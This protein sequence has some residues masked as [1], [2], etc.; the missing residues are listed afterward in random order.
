VD[1]IDAHQ[2]FWDPARAAYPWMTA[3]LDA[4][5]RPFGPADLEPLL[6][7]AGIDRTILVQTIASIDETREFL[8]LA[9]TSARIAGVVGW[10]DLTGPDGA[11]SIDALRRAPGGFRLAGIRHQVHDESD[12]QWL[13]RADVA[14]GLAAV[15]AAG[16][17]Y[18]LLVRTR[19]LPAAVAVAQRFP[20]LRLVL[21]HCAKPPIATRALPAEWVAGITALAATPNVWCKVSGL[22]TEAAWETWTVDDLRPSVA[23]V[24]RCFGPQRL[25]FGSDWP[26][27]LLAASYER[28]TSAA[29]ALLGELIPDH[30][31][32]AAVF[33]A[34]ALAAYALG[35][36]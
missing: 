32:R 24:V 26:V 14:R 25:L 31:Q 9:A 20:G 34:N 7:A 10:I 15:E 33:G 5:R 29:R 35:A 23:H 21:D 27:C 2:H 1:T 12:P 18:D 4:I 11:A 36:G 13:L 3:D 30:A 17:T 8:A 28:V 16:L 6:T 19:E 22:V